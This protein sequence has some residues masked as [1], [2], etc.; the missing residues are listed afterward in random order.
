ML[1]DRRQPAAG[2]TDRHGPQSC[3]AGN[4]LREPLGGKRLQ[5]RSDRRGGEAMGLPNQRLE[6][7]PCL[8]KAVPMAK[9]FALDRSRRRAAPGGQRIRASSHTPRIC[10]LDIPGQRATRCTGSPGPVQANLI[11]SGMGAVTAK[12]PHRR[13]PST[14]RAPDAWPNPETSRG[15]A[16]AEHLVPQA[17]VAASGPAT[18]DAEE[19]AHGGRQPTPPGGSTRRASTMPVRGDPSVGAKPPLQPEGHRES[20]V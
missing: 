19:G 13:F 15:V 17:M 11:I 7:Q 18:P 8:L 2:P 12:L 20:R 4:I 16:L 10:N 5:H 9:L 14:P 1:E 3:R 6:A